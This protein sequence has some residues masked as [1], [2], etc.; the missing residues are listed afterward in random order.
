[1]PRAVGHANGS[2]P[3]N[4]VL[5]C[6]RLIAA[7]GS[8]VKCGGELERKRWLLQHGGVGIGPARRGHCSRNSRCGFGPRMRRSVA[9]RP[10]IAR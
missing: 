4:V 10:E 8:L 7:N 3:I 6:H 5:P 2:N 9:L 1:M